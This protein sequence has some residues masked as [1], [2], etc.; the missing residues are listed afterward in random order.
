MA[1]YA[2]WPRG[3]AARHS[4]SESISL[5][6]SFGGRPV[7]AFRSAHHLDLLKMTTGSC[8]PCVFDAARLFVLGSKVS[9][10]SPAAGDFSLVET[11]VAELTAEAALGL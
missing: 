9:P 11:E 5:R 8:M 3:D 1:L 6:L 10:H 2:T 7:D 4:Y